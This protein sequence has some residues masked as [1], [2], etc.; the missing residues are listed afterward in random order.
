[1]LL[2]KHTVLQEMAPVFLY[3]VVGASTRLLAWCRHRAPPLGF[4]RGVAI[5]RLHL[6][7][8][9]ELLLRC[10]WPFLQPA[11]RK[12]IRPQSC[13]SRAVAR[14]KQCYHRAE[15][16]A[17]KPRSKSISDGSGKYKINSSAGGAMP[18]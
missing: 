10:P 16:K 2:N 6:L 4:W 8:L 9:S 17:I 5:V 11:I 18:S 13:L 1:M 7:F 3:F 12:D 15:P 14:K